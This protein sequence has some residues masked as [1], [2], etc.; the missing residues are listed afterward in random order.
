MRHSSSLRAAGRML[1]SA[2]GWTLLVLLTISCTRTVPPTTPTAH[3]DVLVIGATSSGVAA[4][5][6]AA[7]Q[8]RSVTLVS[9]H[10]HLGTVMTRQM[11]NTFD[12]DRGVHG[13][14]VVR[15]IFLEMYQQLGLTFDP[16]HARTVLADA[17][18]R[19]RGITVLYRARAMKILQEGRR[20]TG[21]E[22]EAAA[23]PAGPA[24]R[25]VLTGTVTIDATD[26]AD[27][28]AAAGVAYHLGREASGIDRA[29]QASTLMFRL[30][31]VNWT[32]L[33]QD[34]VRREMP[35]GRAAMFQGYVWGYQSAVRGFRS[36]DPLV[37]ALD[38][39]IGR[40]PDGDVWVNSLQVF[41]VDGTDASSHSAGLARAAKV[42]P[43]FVVYLRGAIPGFA[44]AELVEAAPELY[45]RET[46]HVAGVYRLT[47]GD[48][49]AER[50]FWDRIAAADY[51]IDLHPYH[52]DELNPFKPVRYRYTVP[53]RSLVPHG[54]DGMF[55]ASRSFAATYAAAGSARII[56]TTMAMGEAAGIAAA[57]CVDQRVSPRHLVA[58]QALVRLVQERLLAVG[59]TIEH[60]R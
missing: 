17:I 51:P 4:A 11:L 45:V 34:V 2:A 31:G 37:R 50:H 12:L 5:L 26:D 27:I 53:L 59:A 13:E 14:S 20:V 9:Y 21:V 7:R 28:A 23:A 56:P 33:V 24:T 47:A 39:N 36:G 18:A 44:H 29:M 42:L 54:I 48:I 55:V 46:R 32:E 3:A 10:E 57:V 8:G 6:A 40:Q 60:A 35:T 1:F 25:R 22:I 15:G 43:S 30:R 38:L 49:I 58:D 41:G 16:Y 19:E 52:P